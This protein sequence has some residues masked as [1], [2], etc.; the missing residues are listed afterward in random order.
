MFDS[1]SKSVITGIITLGSMFQSTIYGVNAEF[2][3]LDVYAKGGTIYV[4]SSLDNCF[5]P[6]LDEIFH[7]GQ[8]IRIHYRIQMFS[9]DLEIPF[10]QQ[11]VFREL[12]YDLLDHYY[13][14]QNSEDEESIRCETLVNAKE[15]LSIVDGFALLSR[16]LLND[17]EQYYVKITAYMD[18]IYLPEMD[19]EINL[20]HYWNKIRPEFQTEVFTADIFKK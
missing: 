9:A 2:S 6:D 20:M 5:S 1:L 18:K 4:T 19:Q 10:F 15:R 8:P 7:T 3:S 14:V 16:D 13:F 17:G 12:R 11:N